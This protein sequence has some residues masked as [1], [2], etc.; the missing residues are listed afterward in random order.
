MWFH[1]PR[2]QWWR[3]HSGSASGS[4]RVKLAGSGVF[5]SSRSKEHVAVRALIASFVRIWSISV[6]FMSLLC[7]VVVGVGDGRAGSNS[8]SVPLL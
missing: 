4:G 6:L 8:F 1:T 3:N 2:T 7:C 5:W